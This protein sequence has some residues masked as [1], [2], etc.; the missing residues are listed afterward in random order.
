MGINLIQ[1]KEIETIDRTSK[2]L[3]VMEK[4]SLTSPSIIVLQSSPKY[5]GAHSQT[6]LLQKPWLEQSFRQ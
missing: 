5:I 3:A 4:A 1:N 6:P 2:V